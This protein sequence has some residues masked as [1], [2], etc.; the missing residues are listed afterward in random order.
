VNA[1]IRATIKANP[2]IAATYLRL[3][4]HDC[5]PNGAAGGCDGCI[6]LQTKANAGLL[7]AVQ[8]LAP[9]VAEFEDKVIG[10][11]RADIWSYAA[12]LGAE[13]SQTEILFTDSFLVGRKNCEAVGTCSSKD[14]VFCA[15]NGPDQPTDFPSEDITTHELVTFMSDH[16]GFNA[17][18]TVA[19]MGAHSIG[20]ALPE[21]TGFQGQTG[22]DN[23]RFKLGTRSPCQ[24]FVSMKCLS[25][26]LTHLPKLNTLYRQR[27]LQSHRRTSWFT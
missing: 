13:V 26:A 22:W 21:N 27:L 10:V 23:D 20:R 12:L 4:F 19:I 24:L 11:S 3:G 15:T 14:A 16:F 2:N 5:V 6:N 25:T 1:K 9:I 8:A 17:D 7:T 18:Q